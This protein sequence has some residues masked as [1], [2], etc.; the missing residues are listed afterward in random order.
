MRGQINPGEAAVGP[1]RARKALLIEK[2]FVRTFESCAEAFLEDKE[3][4]EDPS[5][6]SGQ[7]NTLQ[8]YVYPFIGKLG[9]DEIELPHV[10]ARFNQFG[11]AKQ[12]LP[13][14][15]VA[16]SRQFSI[17]LIRQYKKENVA[18]WKGH[19]DKVLAAPG[20]NP[21]GQHHKSIPYGEIADFVS[22]LKLRQGMA[23]KSF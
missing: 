12:R 6:D 22:E 15:C 5:T 21:E 14:V 20:R 19:L 8:S 2:T 7:R 23:Q 10:L 1:M 3:K 4:N 16:V 13:Y 18:R 9:V 17:G 11:T